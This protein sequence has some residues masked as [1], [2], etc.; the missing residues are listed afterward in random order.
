M[1]R[2][3]SMFA[4]SNVLTIITELLVYDA[5]CKSKIFQRASS[6]FEYIFA[7]IVDVSVVVIASSTFF[8]SRV[9]RFFHW[10]SNL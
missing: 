4:I 7:V 3:A 6:P 10:E 1:L 8:S 9:N 2:F 5:L